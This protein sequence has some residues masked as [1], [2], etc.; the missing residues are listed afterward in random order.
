[1]KTAFAAAIVTVFFGASVL[2]RQSYI[3]AAVSRLESGH[4]SRV[5]TFDPYDGHLVHD[6]YINLQDLPPSISQTPWEIS[7][8]GN[9]IWISD[10]GTRRINRF[11]LDGAYVGG[12]FMPQE[13]VGGA[14]HQPFGMA[15]ASDRVYV[16]TSS[17]FVDIFDLD[18]NFLN[19][20]RPP[21]AQAN[22]AFNHG[23]ELLI[24]SATQS[25]QGIS[26][27]D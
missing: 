13:C 17:R 11:S 24:T 4:H 2:A 8:V 23:T 22:D 5:L 9:Q 14:R 12:F 26:R 27:F 6:N 10:R 3:M 1:M 18:G 19:S 16:T 15:V 25:V 21:M 7:N 20:F